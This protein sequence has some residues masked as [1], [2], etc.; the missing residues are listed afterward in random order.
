[1]NITNRPFLVTANALV[2]NGYRCRIFDMNALARRMKN[3]HAA[4]RI[5]TGNA[6]QDPKTRRAKAHGC[7]DFFLWIFIYRA[8]SKDINCIWQL[9]KSSA[10]QTFQ[11]KAFFL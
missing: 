1:M 5:N 3:A 4:L 2:W 6:T 11:T 7:D 8:I 9:S 10:P